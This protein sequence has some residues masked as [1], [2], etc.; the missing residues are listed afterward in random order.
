MSVILLTAD[1]FDPIRKTVRALAAQTVHDRLELIIACPSEESLG[2]VDEEMA[3]F[4]SF[5]I[6]SL[7]KFTTTSKARTAAIQI[8]AAPII[9]LA[10]DHA[11]PEP[12]WA[13]ALIEAHTQP[14]AGVGPAFINAN[15]GIVSW[16]AMIFDYG[17]WTDPVAPGEIDDIPGHNSSWKR[18][19]LLEYGPQLEFMLPAPTI[20]NWA[21]QA[22][23]H[24]LYLEP[25]AKIRHLQVSRLW[26]CLVEQFNV[27]RLFPAVRSKDWP[28]YRRLFYVCSMPVLLMRNLRGWLANFRRVDAKGEILAKAWPILLLMTVV[29]AAGETLGYAF[30]IGRAQEDTLVFDTDR[31]RYANRR[32]RDLAA[33]R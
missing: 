26:P 27:A 16:V 3:K 32:D 29:W 21:L 31:L 22:K 6:L 17:R 4:D 7:G 24:K 9:A 1:S 25:A 2:L 8:A 5:R 19:I 33:I 10:E 28:W 15:P 14:W 11:Y 18:S 12:G 20:L 30:G 13:E 23:G